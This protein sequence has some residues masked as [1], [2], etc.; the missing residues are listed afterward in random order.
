[1]IQCL[2]HNFQ[3]QFDDVSLA[4][5]LFLSC[6]N[7]IWSHDRENKHDEF[8]CLRCPGRPGCAGYAGCAPADIEHQ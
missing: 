1:V 4:V 5:S 8:P 3:Y 6:I 7:D 2:S